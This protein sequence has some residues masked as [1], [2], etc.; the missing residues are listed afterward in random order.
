MYAVTNKSG[1]KTTLFDDLKIL[2]DEYSKIYNFYDLSIPIFDDVCK[3]VQ[4]KGYF[5]LELNKEIYYIIKTT[6]KKIE[7]S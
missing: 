1:N 7:N 2:Y 4:N 5:E 6:N 3:G